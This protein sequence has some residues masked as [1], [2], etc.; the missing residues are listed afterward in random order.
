M[1]V[2]TFLK[3][4]EKILTNGFLFD[5]II[6]DYRSGGDYMN[7]RL[8]LIRTT[9]K[10]KQAEFGSRIGLSQNTIANY[11]CGRRALTEQTIK[12]ICRE[13]NV[14]YKWLVYGGSDDEMF[15]KTDNTTKQIDKILASENETAIAVFKAFA[16]LSEEE[17]TVVGNIIDKIKKK[18]K[19][20]RKSVV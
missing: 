20:D 15:N 2:N 8:K 6:V 16:D 1:F 11:E 3:F 13:F 17:W 14:N 9:L 10:M 5:N 7:E 18:I 12:S 19:P 4:F